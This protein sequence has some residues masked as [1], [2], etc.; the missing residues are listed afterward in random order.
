MTEWR[1]WLERQ[2]NIL[3]Q[4]K[5]QEQTVKVQKAKAVYTLITERD[6]LLISGLAGCTFL[7]GSWDKRFVKAMYGYDSVERKIIY[8]TEITEKQRGCL[9]E[10]YHRYRRQ[11][12]NHKKL[13]RK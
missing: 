6:K 7:P 1:E 13:C 5:A 3:A 8:P 2:K 12:P 9:E 11:I 4:Q 10:L